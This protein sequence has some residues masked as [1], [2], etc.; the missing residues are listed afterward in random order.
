MPASQAIE[1]S[2]ALKAQGVPAEAPHCARGRTRLGETRHQLY[3]MNAEIEW[4][5]KYVRNL[6]YTPERRPPKTT[7]TFLADTWI[8]LM[9]VT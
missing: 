4:F 5:E 7:R 9:P 8:P 6:P 3:K 2:R 1:L